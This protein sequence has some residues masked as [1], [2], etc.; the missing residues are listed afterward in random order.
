MVVLEGRTLL[1]LLDPAECW[2]RIATAP[3]GRIAVLVD[4][5][6]EIYPV[7]FAVDGQSVV[8]RTDGGSKFRGLDRSPSVAFEVDG[9]DPSTN[10]GWSVL[11]KGQASRIADLAELRAVLEL[12]LELWAPGTKTRWI[13]IRPAEITGRAIYPRPAPK[14]TS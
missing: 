4:S 8:F 5:A 11:I 14:G 3:I 12:P 1:E 7:N 9:V 2:R 13:R 6:P 10:T